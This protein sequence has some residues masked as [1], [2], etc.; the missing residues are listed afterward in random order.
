MNI[1]L[2][3]YTIEVHINKGK[4]NRKVAKKI[5]LQSYSYTSNQISNKTALIK[6]LRADQGISLVDAKEAIDSM[7][8]FG[9]AGTPIIK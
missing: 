5:L 2:L 9:N 3:G 6:A 7:F 1:S 8:H 4:Y